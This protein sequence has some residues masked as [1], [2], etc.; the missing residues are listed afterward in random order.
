MPRVLVPAAHK[1]LK[2]NEACSPGADGRSCSRAHAQ[3]RWRKLGCPDVWGHLR[4]S[5]VQE[6]E[7]SFFIGLWG[8]VGHKPI[9]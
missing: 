3:S 7:P 8:S 5:W 9:L 1:L 6:R 2:E 4:G